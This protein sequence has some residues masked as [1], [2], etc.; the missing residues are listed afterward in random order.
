MEW[1]V[2]LKGS[3]GAQRD[4]VRP[5]KDNRLKNHTPILGMSFPSPN[6]HCVENIHLALTEGEYIH[7]QEDLLIEQLNSMK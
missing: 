3:D 2:C 4:T 6:S 7:I 5:I 1:T